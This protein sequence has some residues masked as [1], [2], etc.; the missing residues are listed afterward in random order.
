LATT[1]AAVFRTRHFRLIARNAIE[2]LVELHGGQSFIQN[3]ALIP[4]RVVEDP[5]GQARTI[6]S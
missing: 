3:L 1:L 2:F 6:P 4:R 5:A